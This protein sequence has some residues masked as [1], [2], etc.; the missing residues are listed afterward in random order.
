MF[1]K[2]VNSQQHILRTSPCKI[3]EVCDLLLDVLALALR[4][5]LVQ[6]VLLRQSR[7][8]L[9]RKF[10]AKGLHRL[11]GTNLSQIKLVK[12]ISTSTEILLYLQ[13]HLDVMETKKVD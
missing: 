4:V 6:V 2:V 11:C 8:A 1:C 5:S 7:D 3:G 12:F 10:L 9:L 13:R